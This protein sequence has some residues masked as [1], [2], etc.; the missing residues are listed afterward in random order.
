VVKLI[1]I[2]KIPMKKQI[3]VIAAVMLCACGSVPQ[4]WAQTALFSY[5]D[6]SGVPN[7]GSYTPGSS[8]TFSI[9]LAFTPGGSVAN[10]EG[11]SYWFEQQNPGAPFNFAITNRDVTGSSFTDLQTPGLTYPQNMTPQSGSDLGAAL[12]GPTGVG[13]GN[14]FIANVTVSISATAA[15][16]TY[17]IEN[18]TSAGKKSVISDDAG[19]TFAIPAAF[20]TIT[21]VPEPGT[22]AAGSLIAA[23]LLFAQR[24]KIARRQRV[25]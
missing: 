3:L 13:T 2:K 6:G 11:L 22:W 5:N 25:R 18:T 24:R 7:A 12:P 17:T 10:L 4:A 19:N 1:K 15:L 14:Y 20:Y 21:V 16:G 23:T 9:S 8:F